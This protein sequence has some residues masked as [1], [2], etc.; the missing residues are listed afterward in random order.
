MK[1]I[2]LLFFSVTSVVFQATNVQGQCSDEVEALQGCWD[3]NQ[4]VC[5]PAFCVLPPKSSGHLACPSHC[6]TW[7]LALEKE[8]LVNIFSDSKSVSP[9]TSHFIL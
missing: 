3:A 1:L 8:F 5:N 4:N 7:S 2:T 9:T 6:L